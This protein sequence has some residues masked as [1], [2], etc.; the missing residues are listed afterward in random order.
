MKE[1]DMRPAV[2]AWLRRQGASQTLWES[3]IFTNADLVGVRFA[4]RMGRAI[5]PLVE[6]VVVELK[7]YDIVGMW[8]QARLHRKYP[9][10]SFGAMP[11]ER[12]RRM[13]PATIDAF[14][15]SGVGLLSVDGDRVDVIVPPRKSDTEWGTIRKRLWRRVR[16]LNQ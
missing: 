1:R 7:M 11:L 13:L 4:E 5:P 2:D 10:S 6:V 12:I 14:E 9:V 3:R 8:R 16:E 15:F